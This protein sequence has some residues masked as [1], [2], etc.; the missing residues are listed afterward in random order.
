MLATEVK[1][2]EDQV[3]WLFLSIHGQ[4]FSFV[5]KIENPENA[6]YKRP[7]RA[8]LSFTVIEV[9]SKIVELQ[10]SYEALRGQEL[11]GTVKLINSLM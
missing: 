10:K 5:Y 1:P 7:F 3:N 6:T 2:N 11:I 8:S 9:V 4:H